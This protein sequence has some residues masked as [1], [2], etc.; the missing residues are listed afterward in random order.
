MIICFL[1]KPNFQITIAAILSVIYAFLMTASF[2]SIIGNYCSLSFYSCC[3][4]C[5]GIV[6]KMALVTFHLTGLLI[7]G[8]MV[9]QQTFITP[10]GLFLVSGAIMYLV[11]AILHPQESTL[12]IYGLMYFI[13]IPSGYLL[14]TIYSLVN[15]HIVS[16]GTRE[17]SKGKEQKKQVGVVCNRDCK[18]CCWDVKI[19]VTQETENLL[20]Q[21]MQQ[22]VNPNT[23]AAKAEPDERL[24]RSTQ[25]EHSLDANKLILETR[26]M[27]H[28]KDESK[29]NL[30]KDDKEKDSDSERR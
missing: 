8:D 14:L 4:F 30:N 23:P 17:T 10:T 29:E 5:I 28:K 25:E 11:T 22:A 26:E 21:Q 3:F 9:I 18:M 19:Q 15:M 20:L 7:L 12:I 2:F 16:W 24:A 27:S 6:L 1:A 13:C